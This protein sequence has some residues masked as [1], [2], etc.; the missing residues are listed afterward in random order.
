VHSCGA[1][2]AGC[3]LVLL[4]LLRLLVMLLMLLVMLLL[5]WQACRW[6]VVI[7]GGAGAGHLHLLHLHGS[8][9]YHI[10]VGWLCAPVQRPMVHRQQDRVWGLQVLLLLVMLMGGELK[11]LLAG[12][13]AVKLVQQKL[14][15]EARRQ[16]CGVAEDGRS[17]AWDRRCAAMEAACGKAMDDGAAGAAAVFCVVILLL[18]LLRPEAQLL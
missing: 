1:A 6:R 8:D 11:Q 14:G 2:L 7:A 17:A 9:H 12:L 15:I 16:S 4:C 18:L 3:H 13:R 10:H 5:P